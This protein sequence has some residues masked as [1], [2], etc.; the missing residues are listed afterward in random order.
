MSGNGGVPAPV[1]C[2]V[3]RDLAGGV[4]LRRSVRRGDGI[5]AARARL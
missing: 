4:L 5:R 1:R 3:Q 2:F